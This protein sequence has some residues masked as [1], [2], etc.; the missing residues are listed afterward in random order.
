MEDE[1]WIVP[2]GEASRIEGDPGAPIVVEE[3]DRSAAFLLGFRTVCG[4]EVNGLT[5]PSSAAT[6]G[7][8]A[9]A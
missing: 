1:I 7:G 2:G 3:V 6:E 9:P 4:L 8:A 5:T